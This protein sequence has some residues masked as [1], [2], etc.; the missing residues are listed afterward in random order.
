MTMDRS[1]DERGRQPQITRGLGKRVSCGIAVVG[2]VFPAAVG[3]ANI[4]WASRL[5]SQRGTVL[6]GR[7]RAQLARLNSELPPQPS[8]LRI[9]T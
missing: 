7:L 8:R 4:P 1:S 9:G 2:S 6:E 3:H 5:K